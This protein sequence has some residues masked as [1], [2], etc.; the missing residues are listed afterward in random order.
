MFII[1][2]LSQHVSGIIM[3]SSGEQECALPH[4]VFCTGCDGCGCVELGRELCALRRLLFDN[5]HQISC[6]LL[7]SLSS[8]YV[9]DARSQES[10]KK[11][12][13][14]SVC[15]FYVALQEISSVP[16]CSLAP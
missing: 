5:K 9:H 14:P 6:I 8:P 7:I 3:P 10:K 12:M 1:K 16:A 11:K 4:M 2:L 13:N 15:M